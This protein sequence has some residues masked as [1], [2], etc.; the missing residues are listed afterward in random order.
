MHEKHHIGGDS[1]KKSV[2]IVRQEVAIRDV[3]LEAH[4]TMN[5]TLW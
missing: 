1:L 2:S 4:V 5:V 3:I